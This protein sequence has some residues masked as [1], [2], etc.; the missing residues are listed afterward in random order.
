MQVEE[1][2]ESND[3]GSSS[4]KKRKRD[5]VDEQNDVTDDASK[6]KVQIYRATHL[7]NLRQQ[8]DQY[9]LEN[10]RILERRMSVF[11]SL[12]ELHECY[13]TGLDGIARM[14]DLRNIPDNVIMDRPSS[15]S[16][17]NTR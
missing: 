13:E 6:D 16:N 5:E 10:Q 12:V 11:N 2:A 4:S 17:D 9:K 8:L 3:E 14:N 7:A 15:Q 1:T